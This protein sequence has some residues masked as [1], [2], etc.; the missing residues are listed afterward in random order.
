M[1]SDAR[2]A[3]G[4]SKEVKLARERTEMNEKIASELAAAES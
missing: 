1:A 3:A 2:Q 4:E